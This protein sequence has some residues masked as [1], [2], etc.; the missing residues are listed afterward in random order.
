ML[1][2]SYNQ[3]VILYSVGISQ[4]LPEVCPILILSF[5]SKMFYVSETW[6]KLISK[7][8]KTWRNRSLKVSKIYSPGRRLILTVL[9]PQCVRRVVSKLHTSTASGQFS[10][11][12]S[13]VLVFW[14]TP[15]S[16]EKLM[17]L[18]PPLEM[19]KW[20]V[21]IPLDIKNKGKRP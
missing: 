6:L 12:P 9:W 20:I 5:F 14:S 16:R 15:I 8:I 7:P 19:W 2:K 21:L 1:T 13:L 11:S 18:A 10:C 17:P 4:I 3:K